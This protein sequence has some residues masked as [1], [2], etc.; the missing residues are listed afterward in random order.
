[1]KG[2]NRGTI[3]LLEVRWPSLLLNP[4]GGFGNYDFLACCGPWYLELVPLLGVIGH[5]VRCRWQLY[6]MAL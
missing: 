2:D 1:M 5:L 3:S 6:L 4:L